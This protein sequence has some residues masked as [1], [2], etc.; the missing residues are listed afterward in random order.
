MTTTTEQ[1][2]NDVRSALA[3]NIYDEYDEVVNVIDY[4][5]VATIMMEDGRTGARRLVSGEQ[6]PRQ[7]LG[8]ALWLTMAAERD[9]ADE[10]D[11]DFR[12]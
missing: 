1:L 9:M 5:V 10:M 11:E 12:G 7:I 3:A 2:E 6:N 8:D 4:Q